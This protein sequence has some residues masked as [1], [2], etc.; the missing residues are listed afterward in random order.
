MRKKK[1]KVTFF[2]SRIEEKQIFFNLKNELV[3]NNYL[4]E[5][6]KNLKKKA[7]IGFYCER[8]SKP[9]NSKISAIFLGGIDQGRL[10]W[11]N[12][13]KEQPWNEFDLGFLPGDN[14]A[15]RW[16][17]SS[18]YKPSNTKFGVF[19]VGWPKADWLF[20]QN[21]NKEITKN[22]IKKYKINKKKINIL[23]A[24]SFE[25]FEKQLDV[26]NAVKEMKYNLLIKHWLTK[27]EPRYKDLWN[28]IKT[29]NK[30]SKK[31]YKEKTI[32]LK[33]NEN[34]LSLLNVTD[35]IITDESSVAYEG[36]L[37][38]IPTVTVKDW[39]IAR[40]NRDVAR[41]VK[42]ANIT[43]KSQKKYLA[44]TINKMIKKRFKKKLELS[45]KNEFSYL[46]NSSKIIVEILN[47]FLIDKASVQKMKYFIKPL[48]QKSIL[49][50]ILYL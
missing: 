28:N 2:Y 7:D 49:S 8:D 36:L 32:I 42:P 21:T 27:N 38:H 26:T 18:G 41:L 1:R 34:F 4:V 24:P 11:P 10:N 35:L 48:T 16:K 15:K 50:K 30:L 44:Q 46:G 33:P 39:K 20:D 43:F 40:H 45:L 9:S 31:I 14:W 29:A 13:W 3:K 19:K 12:I 6:S 17:L 37:R 5:F 23:Y 47:Q 22:L 25:C